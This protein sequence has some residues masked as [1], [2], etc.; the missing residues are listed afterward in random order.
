LGV[1]TCSTTRWSVGGVSSGE[2]ERSDVHDGAVMASTAATSG[3][4]RIEDLAEQE[5]KAG[6]PVPGQ[7]ADYRSALDATRRRG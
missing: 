7:Q 6:C 3:S 1:S 2:V 4:G 5:V